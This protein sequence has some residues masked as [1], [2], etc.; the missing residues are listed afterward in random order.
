MNTVGRCTCSIA[1]SLF[2]AVPAFAQSNTAVQLESAFAPAHLAMA[3]LVYTPLRGDDT[4]RLSMPANLE[5]PA[6]YRELFELMLDRSPTFRRQCMRIAA[7][8]HL[9]VHV[10]SEAAPGRDAP[11]AY[12][13][14]TREEDGRLIARVRITAATSNPAELIAHE[15]EHIVE[16]LDGIDLAHRSAVQGSGVRACGDGS[17]ETVRAKRIGMLV[18]RE[19]GRVP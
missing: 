10:S 17:Y 7:A 2:L 4:P 14:I 13:R 8:R 1:S 12:T 3:M 18:A 5:V 11:R 16:Q 6:V 9:T 19:A 15:M